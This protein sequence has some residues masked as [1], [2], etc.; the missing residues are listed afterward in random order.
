MN[1]IDTLHV[2]NFKFFQAQDAIKLEGNHLLLYGENGSGKSSVYWAL[3]TL[4]E[5]SLKP[6]DQQ[7]R[8]YFSKTILDGEDCLVNIHATETAS[9]S[10]NFNSF[11]EV[12]TDGATPA[13]FRISYHD[14][15]I[16]G[17]QTAKQVNY[18]SDY[19]N[20]RL[21]LGFSSFRH[22]EPIDLFGLFR[23]NIFYYVRFQAINFTRDGNTFPLTSPVDMWK[24]I[25][26][27]PNEFDFAHNYTQQ[28]FEDYLETPA[29]QDYTAS[30]DQF[31]SRL[32]AL[33][34]YINL[35]APDYLKKLGYSNFEFQLDLKKSFYTFTN[36]PKEYSLHPFAIAL[37][38]TEY[39]GVPKSVRKPH[40]FLNEARFSAMAIAIRL[41]ILK[42][43]LQ[44][45][46][47][48]FIVLDDL[49]IS[50]D[51]RNR[52]RVLD[53][54]LSPEFSS[55]YQIIILSHDRM[56]YQLAK[57]KIKELQQSNWVYY[58]MFEGKN[59]NTS[60]PLIIEEVGYLGKATHYLGQGELDIAA[61]FLRKEAEAFCK[62][63]LPNRLSLKKDGG[64]KDLS[65]LITEALALAKLNGLTI[66]PFEAL[67]KHR[68]FVLNPGSHDSYDVPKYRN[69]IQDC[70]TNLLEIRK[71][72]LKTV[73]QRGERISFE[74]TDGT[75]LFRFDIS[76]EEDVKLIKEPNTSSILPKVFINYDL[77]KNGTKTK[78]NVQHGIESIKVLYDKFYTWS[79]KAKNQDYWEEIIIA[80][81][82]LPLK[83]I[84]SY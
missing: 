51:M 6:D 33:I 53:L 11:I 26:K 15:G 47:L 31:H 55:N 76:I 39:D 24:D 36:D 50:L 13:T 5:A 83:S 64:Y 21:L 22:S 38:I 71:I 74:H 46:C 19:I 7:I 57:H 12:I 37:T 59:G 17:N 65:Q 1:R 56:F 28:E 18:A 84:R 81:T 20:Y 67:D 48:K 14:I 78:P 43:K 69:E 73:L 10:D 29:Y 70:L 35:H 16:R 52:E 23:D 63:L 66:A 79:N 2:H 42:Q 41:A 25:E 30:F 62:E 45:N 82:G 49:L 27:G 77:F 3:Y 58:E 44:E 54:L 72:K 68:K 34:D 60:Y 75:D 40:S 32:Q 61:N 9:G 4:F 80:E 8:K